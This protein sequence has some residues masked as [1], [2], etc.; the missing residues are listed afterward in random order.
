VFRCSLPKALPDNKT[1]QKT[2]DVK[3]AHKM[4]KSSFAP[5]SNS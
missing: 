5:T 3:D 2:T 4:C 1:W